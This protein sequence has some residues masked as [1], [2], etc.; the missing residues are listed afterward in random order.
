[1]PMYAA[2]FSRVARDAELDEVTAKRYLLNG[3]N[4]R[5]R[6]A[7]EGRVVARLAVHRDAMELS[8]MTAND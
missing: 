6:A 1:M 7:L 5:S 3:L 2:Q 4:G 8:S